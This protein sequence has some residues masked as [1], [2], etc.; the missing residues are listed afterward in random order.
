M[1]L[2]EGKWTGYCEESTLPI[3]A[4]DRVRIKKGTPLRSCNPKRPIYRALTTY[5]VTVH[6]LLPGSTGF[7]GEEKG[8][9]LQDPMVCWPGAGSYWVDCNI[10]YAEKL[11]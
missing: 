4:G 3:K 9:H 11:G 1:P 8:R 10:N 7:S 2:I 5:V 6:H